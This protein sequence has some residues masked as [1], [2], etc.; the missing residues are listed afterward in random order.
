[1]PALVDRNLSLAPPGRPTT[2]QC[3]AVA[4]AE[5][6]ARQLLTLPAYYV[7]KWVHAPSADALGATRYA[8]PRIWLRDDLE[9]AELYRVALHE[10]QHVSDDPIILDIA[11]DEAERRAEAFVKRALQEDSNMGYGTFRRAS[12]DLL[13]DGC[14]DWISSGTQHRAVGT[15]F[16]HLACRPRN[17]HA[18]RPVSTARRC[19]CGGAPMPSGASTSR[20]VRCGR[21]FFG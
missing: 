19:L 5:R 8:P 3:Q 15:Q 18:S 2:A 17:G 16:L 13:C 14:D 1:M 9:P 7:V 10:L 11:A 21:L 4:A 6:R 12:E 20:C